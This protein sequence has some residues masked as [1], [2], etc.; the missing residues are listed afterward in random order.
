M[1]GGAERATEWRPAGCDK[2]GLSILP[3]QKHKTTEGMR[4][5]LIHGCRGRS[6]A[7]FSHFCAKVVEEGSEEED[8]AF[9]GH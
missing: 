9:R 8:P 3:G 4:Q 6:R 1:C 2:H 5:T 7:G